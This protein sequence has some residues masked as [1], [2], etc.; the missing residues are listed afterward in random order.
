MQIFTRLH[1]HRQISLN[2][3]ISAKKNV[4]FEQSASS[5]AGKCQRTV[6]KRSQSDAKPVLSKHQ[7]CGI[8]VGKVVDAAGTLTEL[9][10][11]R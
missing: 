7:G 3:L 9:L 1:L 2:V 4:E 8:I 5:N 10:M 11:K 6:Q